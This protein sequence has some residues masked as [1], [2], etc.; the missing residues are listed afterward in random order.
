[1]KQDCRPKNWSFHPRS[2][3]CYNASMKILHTADLHI[4]KNHGAWDLAQDQRHILGQIINALIVHGVDVLVVAGDLFDRT[5]PGSEAVA[6]ADWFFSRVLAEARCKVVLISGNHDSPE[7]VGYCSSIME[8]QGFHIVTRF[9]PDCAPLT[10]RRQGEEL[11]MYPV[12]FVD[13]VLDPWSR[14]QG[15]KDHQ[16]LWRAIHGQH[17][18]RWRA[19]QEEDQSAKVLLGHCFVSGM[20]DSESERPLSIGGTSQVEAGSMAGFDY[21]ALGHLHRPQEVAPGIRYSGSPLSYSASEADQTKELVLVDIREKGNISSL[22]IPLK[23]LHPV[24]LVKATME[25]ILD[26]PGGFGFDPQES[27]VHVRLKNQQMVHE[28]YHRLSKVFTRLVHVSREK[29]ELGTE[30]AMSPQERKNLVMKADL[31]LLRTFFESVSGSGLS[32]SQETILSDLL[33]KMHQEPSA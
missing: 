7:R 6:L 9:D 12:P 3:Q 16:E 17:L 28:A 22:S 14:N 2:E 5:L 31:P 24:H 4:G 26:N 8:N 21:V 10:I 25:E 20:I 11:L 18:A 32:A 19:S 27:F 33:Q 15:L 1:M 23:P 30:L 29:L 13:P